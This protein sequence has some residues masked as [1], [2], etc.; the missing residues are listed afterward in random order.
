MVTCVRMTDASLERAFGLL[1][2]FLSED[3]HYRDSHAAYS[4]GGD[5]ALRAA[6]VQFLARPELGFGWL[7]NR[8]DE[9]V[10][11]CVV[12]FAVSTSAGGLVAKL[13]DVYV[14]GDRRGD[15]VGSALLD[16]LKDE[17]RG[18]GVLRIDTSVHLRNRAAKAFYE[19]RGFVPLNE[20]R[21]AFVFPGN[22]S[23]P[24]VQID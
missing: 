13:D 17:L 4:D 23:A 2:T 15:G 10:G 7:A 21:L 24:R 5:V 8:G 11:V 9:A 1:Q 19:R 12:S 6:L 3:E 14:R 20:E 16:S 22:A 18:L